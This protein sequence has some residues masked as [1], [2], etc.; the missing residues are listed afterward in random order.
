MFVQDVGTIIH[1]SGSAVDKVSLDMSASFL[2]VRQGPAAGGDGIMQVSGVAVTASI[3]DLDICTLLAAIEWLATCVSVATP[4][5]GLTCTET[6]LGMMRCA[7]LQP[8]SPS[9]RRF[10]LRC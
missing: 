7:G 2:I 3:T 4:F 1:G 5:A 8:R 10:S 6:W 9:L